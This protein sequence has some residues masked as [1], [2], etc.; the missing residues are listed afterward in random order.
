MDSSAQGAGEGDAVKIS[1]TNGRSFTRSLEK[2]S[3]KTGVQ[4]SIVAK[5]LAFQAFG[6]GRGGV[7]GKTPVDTGW[8]RASWRINEGSVDLT[9]AGK[10]PKGAVLAPPSAPTVD[11]SKQF[12]V[13]YITNNLPYIGELEKGRS[14]QADKGFMVQRTIAELRSSINLL[15]REVSS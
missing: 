11:S 5:R 9:V 1:F 12:P 6:G 4:P 3:E 15:L 10:P 14:K 7:V 8:A 13:W 2:F